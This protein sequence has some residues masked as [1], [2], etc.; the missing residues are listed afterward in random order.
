MASSS[1]YRLL[2]IALVVFGA[3]ML[4][5]YPLAVVWPSGWAWHPGAPYQSDYFM[6][7]VGLYATLGAFLCNAAR[8]PEANISLIWF[9]VVS[10]VVHA[11]IMAVQSFGNGHHMGHL[12][13]DVLALLLAA[14]VLSVLM[15]LSGL[16]QPPAEGVASPAADVRD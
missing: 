14:I 10:S 13:G 2:Q 1:S 9:A 7:I 6:M 3:V 11:A 12:W 4:L 5:L 16:K 8:R 15:R